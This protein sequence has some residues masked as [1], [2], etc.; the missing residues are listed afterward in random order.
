MRAVLIRIGRHQVE[1]EGR[2]QV[3]TNGMNRL[4][5]YNLETGKI[6]WESAGTNHE[7]DSV[8]GGGR[9]HGLS[10]ERFP[11]QQLE[12]HQAG[13]GTR[14][15]RTKSGAIAWSL[16][17]DTPYVPS[18]LLYNGVLYF[19]KTNSGVFSLHSMRRRGRP[20]TRCSV[21]I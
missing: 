1:H 17:R 7:P 4:R 2:A 11:R 3:V 14:R 13:R 19:L 5:S 15:H 12:S 18:P 16:D 21:W 6:V 9:W 10:D 8:A 20:T